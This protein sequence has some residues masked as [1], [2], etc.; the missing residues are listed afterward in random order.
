MKLYAPYYSLIILALLVGLNG[1]TPA[2]RSTTSVA[3]PAKIPALLERS[4]ANKFTSEYEVVL[5]KYGDLS[6]A[7]QSNPAAVQERLQM[8]ALFMQEARISGEHGYYY[9]EA[10]ALIEN[11]LISPQLNE[12]AKVYGLI[13]KAHV[14][15]AQHE[16]ALALP[17]AEEAFKLQP[18]NARIYTA[19]IDAHVELGHYQKAV[20]LADELMAI[21]PNLMG[22][23]RVSYLRELYGDMPGAI[24]AMRMAV[25]AGYP[26]VEDT[27]WAR[28][29]LGELYEKSGNWTKAEQ[30]Y[31][32]SLAVRENYAFAEAGM[33]RVKLK[34][35][36]YAEAEKLFKKALAAVPEISFQEDLFRLYQAWGK[37]AEAEQAY[38]GITSMVEDDAAKGHRVAL[39]YAKILFDL[40][41]EK[42]MA[43][44]EAMKEFELRPDNLDV[45][46]LLTRIYL[47]QGDLVAA[48]KY[49]SLAENSGLK[50][51]ELRQL[52]KE[53]FG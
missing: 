8:A 45:N 52:R 48:K 26:G 10:L 13:L 7:I 14:L 29:K 37:A 4:E 39:D 16:F 40:G 43:L 27:E 2:N 49:F 12:D 34:Q 50:T 24:E 19:L 21:R 46:T 53:L 44:N 28:I 33:A 47:A 30:A 25:E 9:P 35:G 36:Q 11:V 20:Q 31:L 51:P 38:A 23:A 32:S 15:L 42:E 22:Y 41:G 5:K 17:I 18:Y 1:C 6:L 3:E